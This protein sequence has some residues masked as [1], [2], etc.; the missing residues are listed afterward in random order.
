MS[1]TRIAVRYAKP[2]L[3]LAEDK[4][5]LEAVRGDMQTF[6]SLCS[7][8]RDFVNMLKSPILSVHKKA[9]IL[10]KI[11]DSKI[12]PLTSQFFHIVTRKN[13]EK[14]LPEIAREFIQLY[15]HKMGYQEATVI[16]AIPIDETMKKSFEEKVAAITGKKP[17]LHVKL[18][19]SLIGGYVLQLGDQQINESI[20]G[21]LND[22]KLKFQK[23]TI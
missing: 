15:N 13:R 11:F 2:L 5:V 7:T 9:D 23:E 6:V 19:K 1:L 20:S 17:L 3:E 14:F 8:N 10:K 4:N 22:L 16:T 12:N 21:Q 18:D